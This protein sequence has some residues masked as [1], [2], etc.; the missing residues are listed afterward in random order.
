MLFL[1]GLS[2]C[3]PPRKSGG[4]G[5]A[6]IPN[7]SE[8]SQFVQSRLDP[9]NYCQLMSVDPNK[10]SLDFFSPAIYPAW[11]KK[12]WKNSWSDKVVSTIEGDPRLANS[13]LYNP[14][15]ISEKDLVSLSCSGF[16]FATPDERKMFW[17]VYFSSIANI[18]SGFDPSTSYGEGDG[19]T[20]LGL[21]QIDKR[22]ANV[23]CGGQD[24]MGRGFSSSDMKNAETNIECGV[25]MIYQQINAIRPSSMRKYGKGNLFAEKNWGA[26]ITYFAT[27]RNSRPASSKTKARFKA[28]IS[29]MPFCSRNSALVKRSRMSCD[30]L[31]PKCFQADTYGEYEVSKN[32]CLSIN[33]S[34]LNAKIIKEIDNIGSTPRPEGLNIEK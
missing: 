26:N 19:T 33:N 16:K 22:A 10:E 32:N 13:M 7:A 15:A 5:G 29:Q 4:G 11:G 3:F 18:E 1:V 8:M 30:K 25:H 17:I 2:A 28:H 21:F 14:N 31:D 27:T 6:Y 34:A 20:S 23:Y 24:A 9:V 12:E